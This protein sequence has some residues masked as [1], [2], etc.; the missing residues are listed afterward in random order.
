[1]V[2]TVHGD[3]ELECVRLA[4]ASQ[5]E[6]R[7]RRQADRQEQRGRQRHDEATVRPATGGGQH[8]AAF[9][10][11]PELKIQI[12]R[13]LPAVVGIFLQASIGMSGARTC[14][15]VVRLERSG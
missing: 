5:I 7:G 12:V 3:A 14:A 8:G 15:R 1:L 6:Y 4:R 13:R 11:P 9:G 10:D 2:Q